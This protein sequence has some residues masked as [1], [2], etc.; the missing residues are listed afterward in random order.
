MLVSNEFIDNR[1]CRFHRAGFIWKSQYNVRKSTL[2]E[3]AV[4]NFKITDKKLFVWFVSW[5]EDSQIQSLVYRVSKIQWNVYFYI[6]TS[7]LDKV[8]N[9]LYNFNL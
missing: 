1:E 3:V 7:Y 9:S 8:L 4:I 5:V 6:C 2:N